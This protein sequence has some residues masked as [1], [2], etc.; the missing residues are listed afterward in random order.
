VIGK[1]SMLKP[2]QISSPVAGNSGVYVVQ[3]TN[4]TDSVPEFDRTQ[5]IASIEMQRNYYLPYTIWQSMMRNAKI[6]DNRLNFY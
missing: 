5:T 6:N 1:V 4:Q 3:V 2:N